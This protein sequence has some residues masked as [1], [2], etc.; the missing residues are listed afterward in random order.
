MHELP[1]IVRTSW[2]TTMLV[3]RM[4]EKTKRAEEL[5]HEAG[6]DLDQTFF[7]L[8]ARAMGF[9]V[10]AEP[11]ERLARCP[12]ISIMLK[13][14][15]P[16]QTEALLLGQAGFLDNANT[17]EPYV[18][19]LQREYEMLKTKFALQGIAASAWKHMRLRPQN[20]PEIRLAQLAAIIR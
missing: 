17:E 9:N 6:K 3:E 2:L 18:K 11:M 7:C 4:E 16:E 12:P 8:L 15:E 13:H 19:T 1:K 20:F 10:N 5:S 14:P